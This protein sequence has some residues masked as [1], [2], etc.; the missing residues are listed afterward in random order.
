MSAFKWVQ[1]KPLKVSRQ[2]L[3]AATK[4][5]LDE[6]VWWDSMRLGLLNQS[7][8]QFLPAEWNGSFCA[9]ATDSGPSNFGYFRVRLRPV[10]AHLG[11]STTHRAIPKPDVHH[12]SVPAASR[13]SRTFRRGTNIPKSRHSLGRHHRLSLNRPSLSIAASLVRSVVTVPWPFLN[14]ARP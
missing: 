14:E 9:I 10:R 8:P 2:T 11:R 5:S 3:L 12:R 4:S 13:P 1:A 6:L 7:A